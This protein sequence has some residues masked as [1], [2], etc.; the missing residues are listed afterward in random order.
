MWL[1]PR[2]SMVYYHT[3][4][5]F[6]QKKTALIGG[7]KNGLESSACGSELGRLLHTYKPFVR[8]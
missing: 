5:S 1:S 7:L 3:H 4:F 2:E 8:I 6:C